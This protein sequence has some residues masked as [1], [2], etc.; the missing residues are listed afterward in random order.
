[1]IKKTRNA[2]ERYTD[3]F[4][5]KETAQSSPGRPLAD[6]LVAAVS[7][8]INEAI[9]K[10]LPEY[11]LMDPELYNKANPN[12]TI[13]V[14][15]AE[16]SALSLWNSEVKEVLVITSIKFSPDTIWRQGG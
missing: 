9:T 3:K 5:N 1:M 13:P 2:W 8:P 16:T 11:I 6:A 4:R 12:R 10:L 7:N 14:V 15:Q